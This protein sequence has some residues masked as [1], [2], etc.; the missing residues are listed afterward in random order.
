MAEA[1][2]R[3]GGAQLIAA[4]RVLCLGAL[5]FSSAALVDGARGHAFCAH[6]SG[7]DAVRQSAL[8]QLLG[9]QLPWLG[10]LGFSAVLLASLFGRSAWQRMVLAFAVTAGLAGLA[11]LALQLFAIGA[12]CPLCLG[13]DLAAMAAGGVGLALLRRRDLRPPEHTR[14]TRLAWLAALFFALAAPWLWARARPEPAPAFVRA[15]QVPGVVTVV[16][17]SD[18]ECPYCRAL[19]PVL[20]ELLA[21]HGRRVRLVRM[22]IP[23]PGH[24][25][26]RDAARAYYCA[27]A[28]GRGDAMADV[29]FSSSQLQA[30]EIAVYARSIGLAPARF[31][32][33][34]ADPAIDRRIDGDIAKVTAAGFDGLPSVWIG[35]TRILGFDRSAGEAPYAAAL[36]RALH[37]PGPW[38]HAPWLVLALA[39]LV[40][41]WPGLRAL[42]KR[43]R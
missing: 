23:L 22:S 17:L 26:A 14:D 31:A 41:C 16:E 36:E 19:H 3:A 21:R 15:L 5:A 43:A 33:C 2:P 4:L 6:G 28:Q 34:V 8:G 38:Q 27:Q 40:M 12:L 24:P 10:V 20:D 13:A 18:F 42:L 35:Q 7:C 37:G 1:E 9:P 39:A 25:H 32:Q 30:A 11:L 29:L